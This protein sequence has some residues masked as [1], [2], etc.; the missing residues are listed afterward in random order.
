M[1]TLLFQGNQTNSPVVPG[2]SLWSLKESYTDP[3]KGSRAGDIVPG[4]PQEDVNKD[5]SLSF[6]RTL[7]NREFQNWHRKLLDVV[8]F[9]VAAPIYSTIHIVLCVV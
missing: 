5:L 3:G 8:T 7:Q 6:I 9:I 4:I 2:G 1:L